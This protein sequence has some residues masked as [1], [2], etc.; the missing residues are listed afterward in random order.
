MLR[1]K[2]AKVFGTS[3]KSVM[4]RIQGCLLGGQCNRRSALS[5]NKNKLVAIATTPVKNILLTPTFY[6]VLGAVAT[7][8][9]QKEPK[10][11]VSG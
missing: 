1:P 4:P 7:P 5:K 9:F 6:K 2:P 8:V 3:S 10:G 11:A